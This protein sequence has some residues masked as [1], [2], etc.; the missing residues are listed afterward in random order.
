MTL[1]NTNFI[2]CQSIPTLPSLSQS[3][4]EPGTTASLPCQL[5]ATTKRHNPYRSIT[6]RLL[7]NCM[8]DVT[9]SRSIANCSRQ[10]RLYPVGFD[11]SYAWYC[12]AIASMHDYAVSAALLDRTGQAVGSCAG[13]QL[14]AA[15]AIMSVGFVAD[16]VIDKFSHSSANKLSQVSAE[17]LRML[18]PLL[19]WLPELSHNCTRAPFSS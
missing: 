12:D 1:A 3:F 14:L 4:D 19:W 11:R 16:S 17:C 2:R 18:L 7:N 5:H 15:S 6:K 13:E 9:T 10:S 8:Q